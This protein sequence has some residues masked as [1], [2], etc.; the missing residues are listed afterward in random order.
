MNSLIDYMAIDGDPIMIK[1]LNIESGHA[2]F[3]DT[4]NEIEGMVIN[5]TFS[6]RQFRRILK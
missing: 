1:L 4:I 2:G 5:E 6:L 3:D